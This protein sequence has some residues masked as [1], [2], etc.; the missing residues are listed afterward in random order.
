MRRQDVIDK[1]AAHRPELHQLGIE[2]LALFGSV[3]R[4]EASECSDIDLLVTFN[5]EI[6]LFHF[7]R[8]R[9]RLRRGRPRE[10]RYNRPL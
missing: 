6:G 1:L 3:A 4:D 8:V 9:R 7:A 5:R 10:S 2:S